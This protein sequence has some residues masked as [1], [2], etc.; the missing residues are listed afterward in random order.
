MKEVLGVQP[1]HN[2]LG[3][4]LYSVLSFFILMVVLF[5]TS[6][7]FLYFR[8]MWV[9]IEL[10]VCIGKMCSIMWVCCKCVV[11]TEDLI[12]LWFNRSPRNMSVHTL[13]RGL[14]PSSGN[15]VLKLSFFL[16]YRF[17][18]FLIEASSSCALF[19][20]S[21]HCL[22]F[23]EV[24]SPSV[25]WSQPSWCPPRCKNLLVVCDWLKQLHCLV[26]WP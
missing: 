23:M 24:P 12:L 2:C 8:L 14:A 18:I 15:G 21:H 4:L 7:C 25:V 11:L 13:W 19:L 17:W 26:R 9:Q 20:L 22:I 3:V 16:V 5:C 10:W 1:F 6:V